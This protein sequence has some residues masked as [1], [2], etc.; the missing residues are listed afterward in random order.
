MNLI[1]FDIRFSGQFFHP[2]A[3]NGD[4]Q[5]QPFSSD[6]SSSPESSFLSTAQNSTGFTGAAGSAIL[7]LPTP[8]SEGRDDVLSTSTASTSP[9]NV[10][11]KSEPHPSPTEQQQ[12]QQQHQQHNG[13][14]W[15][16]LTPPSSSSITG[17]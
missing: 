16:P 2:T 4:F 10:Q 15:T 8:P 13:T 7:A 9:N 3:N 12:L 5:F 6:F 1:F 17:F 14:T 11:C